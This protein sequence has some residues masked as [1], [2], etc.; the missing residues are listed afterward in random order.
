M[1]DHFLS[2]ILDTQNLWQMGIRSS[3]SQWGLGGWLVG[4]AALPGP[5]E[6]GTSS[7]WM[8][9]F[10]LDSVSLII[11][12][13]NIIVCHFH[14]RGQYFRDISHKKCQKS[15]S[16]PQNFKAFLGR[17]PPDPPPPRRLVPLALM[18][19]SPPPPVTKNLAT[20]V[21]MSKR[22]KKLICKLRT[23]EVQQSS[24]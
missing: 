18:T 13:C 23:S 24:S 5:I 4:A 3:L 2:L 11:V 12:T 21:G 15:I 9:L 7:L 16:E 6:S 22:K 14:I 1:V 17:I 20:A 19:M 10:S 8:D